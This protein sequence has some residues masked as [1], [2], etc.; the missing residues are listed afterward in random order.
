MNGQ[1]AEITEPRGQLWN[2][3]FGS[4]KPVS[5]VTFVSKLAF[6]NACEGRML[7]A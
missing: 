3:G 5:L 2:R 4:G 7:S 6:S 1:G